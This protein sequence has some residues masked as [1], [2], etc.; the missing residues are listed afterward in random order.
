MAA[1]SIDRL[2]KAMPYRKYR[3]LLKEYK[4]HYKEWYYRY[5]RGK[6]YSLIFWIYLCLQ[7]WIYVSV[8][9]F[10]F[11]EHTKKIININFDVITYICT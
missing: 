5:N 11:C 7:L 6:I 9:L 2:T 10:H 1:E 4:G 8:S 3:P